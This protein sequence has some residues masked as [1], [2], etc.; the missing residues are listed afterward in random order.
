MRFFDDPGK[1]LQQMEDEL[2]EEDWKKTKKMWTG[3][4][5]TF[6][7]LTR[8]DSRPTNYAVDFDRTVYDDEET[9]DAYYAEDYIADRKSRKKQRKKGSGGLVLLLLGELAGIAGIIW[10]WIK[11]LS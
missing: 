5:R 2:L 10:W 4:A 9:D 3:M 8:R 6:Q 7:I 11:W 1:A